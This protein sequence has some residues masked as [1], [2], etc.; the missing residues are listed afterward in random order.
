MVSFGSI[1][2]RYLQLAWALVLLLLIPL[3]D[4][5]LPNPQEEYERARLLFL[6]GYLEKSQLAADKGYK[7]Y[8]D[9]G[10]E[11][12][13]KFQL[14]E[15]EAMAWRGMNA[16]ALSLLAEQPSLQNSSEAVL[17]KLLLEGSDL[18]HLLRFSEAEQ[19]L[20][21]AARICK[22]TSY[23]ECGFL[24]R[25]RGILAMARGRFPDAR[26]DFLDSLSFARSDQD[27]WLETTALSN[28]GWVSVQTDHYDEAVDW[29]RSAYREAVELKGEDMA[30][31]ASGNLGWAYFELG[32]KE[33][34]L[35]LLQDAGE[36]ATKL[37]DIRNQINWLE[38]AG[39]VYQDT[40]DLTRA[41]QTYRRSL[42]LAKQINSKGDIVTSLEL[43]THISV[44]A[45]KPD[46]ARIYLEQVKPLVQQDSNRL[47]A[48]DVKLAE[49]EIDAVRNEDQQAAGLFREVEKDPDSQIWMRMGAEHQIA[50][51][52][53]REGRTADAV[54][55]YKTA[56]TT[57]E[58]AREQ[59]KNE[60]S[61]LPFLA[62]A[63]PIYDDYI[64]LLVSLGK[65]QEAL[66][67]ADQ[68]RART[69]AQGLT[70]NSEVKPVQVGGK[71][72]TAP[73]FH[74]VALNPG[75]VAQ[76][77]GATLLFYWLGEK[78]SY[79]W[80]ITPQKTA[81]FPLPAA[82]VITPLVDRYRKALLGT[83]DPLE[84]PDGRELYN[85]LVA[86]AAGLLKPDAQ[87]VILADGALNLLNFETLLAPGPT[88]NS[89]PHYWIED[90]TLLSAPSLAM[91][92]AAKPAH[93]AGRR[94]LLLGDAISPTV[95]YPELANAAAE[96]KEIQKHFAARDEAVFALQ[97]ANPSAY[98]TSN[99]AQYSY[100]HF[101]THGVASQTDPLDSA[102]I[103]SRTGE[104]ENSFKL[105]A[106]EIM[107]HPIDARLVTISACLGSGTK[108][109]AG[110]GLVGLSWAFLRAGS[111]NVIGALWEVSD[112]SSPRLMDALYTNLDQ[113]MAPA[114]ALRK[115]KLGLLH[116]KNSFHRAFYWAPFQLYTRL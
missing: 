48:L 33:Q 90:V 45:G 42:E 59:I 93:T 9:S 67:T 57:F 65:A 14:L 81:L 35:T 20:T 83:I 3:H 77:A 38:T 15:A 34:A 71:T 46:E 115:A 91:M 22:E 54:G 18:A 72:P 52:Y 23:S 25:A 13:A 103:L 6:H 76:K 108:A 50:L 113:G 7:Q 106:R 10:P 21:D 44:K 17:K 12:A 69:L 97:E 79:L 16:N 75:A 62:N 73:T 61:K 26:Q 74:P 114:I 87:V 19:K 58:S 29:F 2:P 85:M 89:L 39:Y 95:D 56:L 84:N 99:P 41:Q 80:A 66:V 70:L 24:P 96:M 64:H 40:G 5:P 104:E 30:Q 102:I 31:I 78:Q 94:L 105:Y 47:D 51:L 92:A 28:L 37:G 88:A 86:P 63:T 49:A 8:I 60:S 112:D 27:R 43:I 36:R 109:Y 107:Q 100:I 101:V 116:S 111:H 4:A 82:R 1:Q 55:M 68:S 53:E 98:L 32:D 110:E 11:W